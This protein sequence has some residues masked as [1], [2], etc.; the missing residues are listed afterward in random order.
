VAPEPESAKQAIA[1]SDV[2]APKA[3]MQN[4][5][6]A[7][8]AKALEAWAAAWRGKNV[9]AYLASYSSKF[10]PEGMSKKA[11]E[12]QRKQRVGA[13][14][15]E[16]TLSLDKVTIEADAKKAKVSFVQHYASGKYSDHVMKVLSFENVKGQW[17][18]V[19]ETAKVVSVNK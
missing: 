1:E 5:H 4:D 10:K 11:W 8:V 6:Q 13:N 15:G 14:A 16:I 7:A 12:A 17:L 2:V 9:E 19:K 3:E 18:I